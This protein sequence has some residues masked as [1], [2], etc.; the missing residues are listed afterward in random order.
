VVKASVPAQAER[1]RL[2]LEKRREDQLR[3]YRQLRGQT[4]EPDERLEPVRDD[5]GSLTGHGLVAAKGVGS[6]LAVVRFVDTAHGSGQLMAGL[7]GEAADVVGWH[8]HRDF[9]A[10]GDACRAGNARDQL[11]QFT[12]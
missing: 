1:V 10:L 7:G 12:G 9:V 4:F 8:V 6:G 2:G 11:T 3:V 5:I